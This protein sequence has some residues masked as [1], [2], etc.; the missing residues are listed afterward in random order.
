MR[1]RTTTRTA[2]PST[3]TAPTAPTASLPAA[4][5]SGFGATKAAWV[6][7]HHPDKAA[8]RQLLA[9]AA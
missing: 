3:T 2:P 1:P 5:L 6:A 4:D 9:Q 8:R 7:G